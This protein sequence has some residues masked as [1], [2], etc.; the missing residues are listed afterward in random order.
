MEPATAGDPEEVCAGTASTDRTLV[1][2]GAGTMAPPL[3][4]EPGPAARRWRPVATPTT[5]TAVAAR[6]TT[7][8]KRFLGMNG[9][10]GVFSS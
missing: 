2:V 6:A 5:S 9:L 10:P 7:I 4:A 1:R 3:G 8:F